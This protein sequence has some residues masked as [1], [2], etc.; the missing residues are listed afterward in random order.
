LIPWLVLSAAGATLAQTPTTP[1]PGRD[2]Q[3]KSPDPKVRSAAVFHLA[4]E[5]RGQ[6]ATVAAVLDDP[7]PGVRATAASVLPDMSIYDASG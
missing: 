4:A 6:P 1:A 2:A 5:R 7:D 3:L